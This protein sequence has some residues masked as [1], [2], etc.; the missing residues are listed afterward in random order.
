MPY[1]LNHRLEQPIAG[2]AHGSTLKN[3]YKEV[4]RETSFRSKP[5]QG[6]GTKELKLSAVEPYTW[7]ES[8]ET[9]K[10]RNFERQ[11]PGT[12]FAKDRGHVW[13]SEKL[14]YLSN[15][16]VG[17]MYTA[18]TT[19]G[20]NCYP[21][22]QTGNG[23]VN[24]KSYPDPDGLAAYG[25]LAYTQAS[26]LSEEFS[27]PAFVGELREGLPSL[28]PAV[29]MKNTA[30]WS[31]RLRGRLKDAKN[32]GSDYLNVQFGWIPLLN[33][34]ISLATALA[35]A[36]VALTAMDEIHRFRELPTVDKTSMV[37][38]T[39]YGTWNDIPDTGLTGSGAP[40]PILSFS[41]V[42]ATNATTIQNFTSRRWFEGNFVKLPK[43]SLGLDSHM[44]RFEWLISTDLTPADLW[45]I[46]PWSWL[47]DWFIDI[48]GLI[49]A[50]QTGTS[51]R[52]LSTYAYAMEERSMTTTVLLRNMYVQQGGSFTRTYNGP[53]DYSCVMKYTSKRRI[54]ANPFGFTL[55]P[56]TALSLGQQLIL[57][58]LGLTK[59]R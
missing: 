46:A 26:P 35:K 57:G 23:V 52:I 16:F 18:G 6:T 54:R 58:A 44:S 50:F 21:A 42:R 56:T 36:T 3:G 20:Y 40:N 32:A 59:I 2:S 29:F 9:L 38:A 53:K 37:E 12:A 55:N 41:V 15:P 10:A 25:A 45:Q 13:H 14:Q 8:Y 47:V 28:L 24:W 17:S 48:G 19:Y 33:D 11:H 22:P 51:N 31:D 1:Y 49:D 30:G 39:A 4:W 7:H 34:V 43:A 5:P 27:L